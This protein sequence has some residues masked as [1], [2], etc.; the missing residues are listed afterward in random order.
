M[1]HDRLK[2]ETQE[3]NIHGTVETVAFNMSLIKRTNPEF[4]EGIK[5]IYNQVPYFLVQ[6]KEDKDKLKITP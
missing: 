5:K 6:K 2:A 1:R 4:Y 3:S